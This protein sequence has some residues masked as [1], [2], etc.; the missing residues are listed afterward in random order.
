MEVFV[1][2]QPI[3]TVNEEVFAYELLYRSSEINR[4]SEIN[5]DEATTDLIINAFMNIGIDELS[6]GKPCFIN[7]TGNLLQLKLPTYFRPSEIVVEILETVE[8]SQE[9][10][11][12][13]KE[14]KALGYQ[15][16]LDDFVFNDKNPYCIPLIQQADIIKV[17][18]RQSNEKMRHVIETIAKRLNKK[19]LAEKIET[20]EEFE[21]A[22]KEGY[23]YYQGYFFSQPVIVSTH[24]VPS[25]FQ[26]YYQIIAHLSESEQSI[27]L[28][29]K[30][31]EQDLS[32][33][34]KLLKL[35]NSP[36]YRPRN[37]INSIRQAIVMLGLIEIRKWIYVLAVRETASNKQGL[38]KEMTSMCL[39]RAKMCEFIAIKTNN[40]NNVSAYFMT[41]MFS[42][43]D[44]M[45]NMPMEKVLQ[46]LP[47]QEDICDALKGMQNH[48][49]D[50]LDLSVAI[51]K[52][53]WE[54]VNLSCTKIDIIE[55]D[56]LHYYQEAIS[57]SNNIMN[58]EISK[59]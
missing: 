18:F 27:D 5:G 14:L 25:Y 36:S 50:A 22:K 32:L 48:F 30:L 2:R 54:Y 42:M 29:T 10:L 3:F 40:L 51:E 39:T 47:L 41:G 4:F 15:I 45:L 12:I 1:A 56:L 7:F 13:C 58:L 46:D 37:K 17:D 21:I 26:S 19:L 57:W 9:L 34:Y 20:R 53:D 55:E 33:S 16:A 43:M 59:T 23:D 44:S 49:K 35:I 28:I 31:I 6:N 8:L 11:D 52:G 24:D 38:S